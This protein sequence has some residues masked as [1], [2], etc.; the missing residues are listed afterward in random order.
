MCLHVYSNFYRPRIFCVSVQGEGVRRDAPLHSHRS[1]RPDDPHGTHPGPVR[2]PGADILGYIRSLARSVSRRRVPRIHDFLALWKPRGANIRWGAGVWLAKTSG[3]ATNCHALFDHPPAERGAGRGGLRRAGDSHA[4]TLRRA[5]ICSPALS[6]GIQIRKPLVACSLSPLS[7][8]LTQ[9]QTKP[10][11]AKPRAHSLPPAS[12]SLLHPGRPLDPADPEYAEKIRRA[13]FVYQWAIGQASLVSQRVAPGE[14][15]RNAQPEA[16]LAAESSGRLWR[17]C[18]SVSSHIPVF[19]LP[20]TDWTEA[21]LP[22]NRRLRIRVED[23]VDN[24]TEVQKVCGLAV[25][26]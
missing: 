16:S 10:A 8:L 25:G 9:R 20:Q 21:H 23:F 12:P 18:T 11:T 6:H 5:Q 1:G 22:P 3:V 14:E 7:R 15:G 17:P 13:R 24:R 4:A 19:R 2:V 26:R